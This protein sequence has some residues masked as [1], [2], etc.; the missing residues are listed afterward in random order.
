VPACGVCGYETADA[1]NFCPD[2]GAAAT[3]SGQE[4]RKVVT[5]LFCDVVGSTGLGEST[6]PE[7]LRALLARYFAEMS[8]I[9][10]HHGGTVEKFIGDAIMAVF[11]VPI[12]HEDDALRACRAA[13]D[14]RHALGGLSLQAR[15]GLTT[16]E[17]VTGTEER[18]ATGDVVNVAAR[19]QQAAEPDEV[20]IGKPTETLV[21]DAVETAALEPLP[22]KGKA[23]PVEAFRLLSVR[24]VE[25]RKRPRFVGRQ[26]EL[27]LIRDAWER[28]VSE[29]R[30]ELVTIA[31]E[32]G[33]GKSRLVAEALK[34]ID[35]RVVQGRC[36]SYGQ[37]VTYWPVVETLKQLDALPSDPASV[38]AIQ[39]LLG[40]SRESTSPEEIAWAFRKLLEEQAPLVV[41]FDDIQWGE[42]TFLDLVEYASLLSSG[43]TVLLL[44]L[45]RPDLTERRPT[46][47]SHS[48]SSLWRTNTSRS[49]CRPRSLLS[50]AGR[51]AMPPAE[52]HC[53]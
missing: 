22:L 12:A 29:Q 48:G 44:C 15:I 51:S 17:V 10:E 33:V 7:A 45:A 5:A 25:P 16:G 26:R 8:A 43:A 35:A 11:G 27:G 47:P 24:E 46:C 53:S 32:A 14:M 9:V 28:A 37:G 34:E 52:I 13:I 38:A 41:V 30:C 3:A 20:L 2:C 40:E 36:P 19:L 1:F 21:R 49:C 23:E 39:A 31:G 42:E 4:Q 18:L 6:D 50:S